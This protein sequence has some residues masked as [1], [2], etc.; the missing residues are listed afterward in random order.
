MFLLAKA[1]G[2]YC[3]SQSGQCP[4]GFISVTSSLPV[5]KATEKFL[6]KEME[7]KELQLALVPLHRLF[8]I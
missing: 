8:I 2:Y 5:E 1:G 6:Q 7:E 4:V 3:L